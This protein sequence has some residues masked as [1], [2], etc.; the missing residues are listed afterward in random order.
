MKKV[1]IIVRAGWD[2]EAEVYVAATTDIEGLAVEAP[3][4]EELRTKVL[5]IIPE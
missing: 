3:T 2:D 1:S 4:V 5:A